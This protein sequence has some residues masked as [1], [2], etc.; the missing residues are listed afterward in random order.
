MYKL[1]VRGIKGCMNKICDCEEKGAG[2]GSIQG[3]V[4]LSI[5]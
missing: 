5:C 4:E 2:G 3:T 1:A